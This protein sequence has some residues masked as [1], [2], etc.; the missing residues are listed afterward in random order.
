MKQNKLNRYL[1]SLTIALSLCVC[2]VQAKTTIYQC[3]FIK[4]SMQGGALVYVDGQGKPKEKGAPD[5]K[6]E[7]NGKSVT[8]Q[9][10]GNYITEAV[11][12]GS[13]KVEITFD[14]EYCATVTIT[15]YLT[16]NFKLTHEVGR[17]W[18]LTRTLDKYWSSGFSSKRKVGVRSL[19]CDETTVEEPEVKQPPAAT[20]LKMTQE[21]VDAQKAADTALMLFY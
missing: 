16:D 2:A 5:I 17:F 6:W 15:H 3:H 8:V 9:K 20:C 14:H 12:D 7:Q 18:T 19:E 4:D 13:G 1:L 11:T 10:P 21:Q